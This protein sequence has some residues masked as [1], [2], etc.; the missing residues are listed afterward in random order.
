MYWCL[1]VLIYCKIIRHWYTPE[2][3]LLIAQGTAFDRRVQHSTQE[4]EVGWECDAF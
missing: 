4:K 3:F 1:R 2:P